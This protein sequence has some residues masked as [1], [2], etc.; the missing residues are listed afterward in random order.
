M[1]GGHPEPPAPR[2]LV[3]LAA[4][5]LEGLEGRYA[6]EDHTLRIERRGAALWLYLDEWPVPKYL[7]PTNEPDVFLLRS[8]FGRIRFLRPSGGAPAGRLEWIFSPTSSVAYPR[9]G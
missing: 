2:P 7:A 8:D 5:E 9:V 3:P 6:T 1:R 4:S